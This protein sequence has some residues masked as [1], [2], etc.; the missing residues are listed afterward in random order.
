MR[1]SAVVVSAGVLPDDGGE[2]GVMQSFEI[3]PTPHG[4]VSLVTFVE[5][6]L[7]PYWNERRETADRLR[8]RIEAVLDYA[9]AKEWRTKRNPA[10]ATLLNG[11]MPERSEDENKVRHFAAMA[12]ADVPAFYAKLAASASTGAKALMFTILTAARSG[13]TRNAVWEEIDF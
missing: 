4:G 11:V 3:P 9:I 2:D 13:K 5:A 8:M 1:G 10:T 12:Y 7:L 6:V